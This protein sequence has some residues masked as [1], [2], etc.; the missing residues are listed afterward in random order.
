[1][2]KGGRTL[3]NG[4][5]KT[6][7]FLGLLAEI[8]IRLPHERRRRRTGIAVDRVSTSERALVGLVSMGCSSYPPPTL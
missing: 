6:L 2:R 8:V 1:V 3:V 4:T 5:L 7:Y